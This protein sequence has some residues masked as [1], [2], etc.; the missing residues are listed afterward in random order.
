M[1]IGK[2]YRLKYIILSLFN[3]NLF[4]PNTVLMILEQNVFK[5]DQT[6]GPMYITKI[7]VE[8]KTFD[9]IHY[10]KYYIPNHSELLE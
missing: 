4:E 9:I 10:N 5:A 8:H 7:L 2:L 3:L 1:E 6:F